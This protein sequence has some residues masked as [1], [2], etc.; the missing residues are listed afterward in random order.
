MTQILLLRSR[1][2]RVKL[3]SKELPSQPSLQ[4]LH[5]IE[6]VDGNAYSP[7]SAMRKEF[8]KDSCHTN[9]CG[10][11]SVV[12]YWDLEVSGQVNQSAAWS[13]ETP[14]TAVESILRTD[15]FLER[16]KGDR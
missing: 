15:H 14:K 16:C 8:Y 7:R 13:Y 5:N 4:S 2:W 11:K 1:P 3:L 6:Y 12:R 10:W 9:I